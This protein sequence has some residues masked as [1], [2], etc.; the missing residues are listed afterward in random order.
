MPN[1]L[2][3]E[4]VPEASPLLVIEPGRQVLAHVLK[5]APATDS[6]K[7]SSYCPCRSLA[8]A[9]AAAIKAT[10]TASES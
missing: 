1:P 4:R 10:T 2:S 6:S 8:G 7:S 9:T 5:S 3:P